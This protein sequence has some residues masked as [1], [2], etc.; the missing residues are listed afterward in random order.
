MRDREEKVDVLGWNESPPITD[1][2][3]PVDLFQINCP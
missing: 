2:M 3:I 1:S